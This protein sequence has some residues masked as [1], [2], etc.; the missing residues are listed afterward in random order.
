MNI[1]PQ[2][3]IDTF[4]KRY[5]QYP[6]ISIIEPPYNPDGF[7]DKALK[8]YH[9]IWYIKNIDENGNT[10]H[11][12][13]LLEFDPTGIFLYIKDEEIIFILSGIDKSNIVDFT[14]H[15]LKKIK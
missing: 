6:S 1:I 13:V 15:N 12:D 9:K 14:I 4:I 10:I 2:H 3:C 7:I 11:K 8:K 5:N